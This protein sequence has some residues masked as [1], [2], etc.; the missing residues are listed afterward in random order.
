MSNAYLFTSLAGETAIIDTGMPGNAKK[1]AEYIISKG[2]DPKM[3]SFI[4]LTHPDIDHSGSLFELKEKYATKAKVAIH[5]EDA[6]RLA[7]E[8]KLKEVKGASGVMMGLFSPFMKFHPVSPEIKL[9][10]KQVIA[11]LLTVHTPGHTLG[12]VCFYDEKG[13]ALLSGDTVIVDKN[14]NPVFSS[15][16]MSYD[17]NMTRNSVETKLKNLNFDSLYPG[18]GPPIIGGASEKLRTLLSAQT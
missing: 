16:S 12:S 1:I 13:R 2:K 7:G 11:D 14:L 17:L 8:T 18:H 4:L 6:P 9:E 5:K 3:V 15:S 10:D